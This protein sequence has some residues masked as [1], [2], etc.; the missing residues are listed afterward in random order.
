[1][2]CQDAPSGSL[3]CT[4]H[5]PLPPRPSFETLA[6]SPS[7]PH[8]GHRFPEKGSRSTI[9]RIIHRAPCPHSSPASPE[10]FSSE[11]WLHHP[12]TSNPPLRSPQ[13]PRY[14]IPIAE[15][16]AAWGYGMQTREARRL[17]IVPCEATH[18]P[19]KMRLLSRAPRRSAFPVFGLAAG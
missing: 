3:G 17:L 7:T 18:T 6:P 2:D 5:A 11:Y 9:T 13:A 15:L 16:R 8:I 12:S 4:I 1:M 10:S 14:R 19:K